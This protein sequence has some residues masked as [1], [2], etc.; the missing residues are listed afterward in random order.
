MAEESQVTFDTAA[1][2]ATPGDYLV[3]VYGGAVA[4]FRAKPTDNPSDIAD[5][6]VSQPIRI[7]VQPADEKPGETKSGETK[8]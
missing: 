1:L 2:K 4:K 8:P 5:I 3:A 7:R 6:V